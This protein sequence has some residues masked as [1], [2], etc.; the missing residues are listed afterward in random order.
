[1][2][3]DE[4]GLWEYLH[5]PSGI[6]FVLIIPDGPFLIGSSDDQCGEAS[7][8]LR[9]K[10]TSADPQV[11]AQRT[12]CETPR[13]TVELSPFLIAK[14][15]VTQAQ[16]EKVMPTNL[17]HFRGADLPVENVSWVESVE[18]CKK[19]KFSLTTEAQW[20]YACRGHTSTPF[21]FGNF[22][23]SSQVN[24]DGRYPYR[25]GQ[26]SGYQKATRPSSSGEVNSFGLRNMHG[27][28]AEWC[29]DDFDESF[30]SQALASGRDPI[31]TGRGFKKV[32]RGGS[33]ND[34]ASE[35][36][37][38]SRNWGGSQDRYPTVGFR[39]ALTLDGGLVEQ[40]TKASFA[41]A[42]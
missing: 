10:T 6:R 11:I 24:F 33:W 19:N 27:N 37:S 7:T 14:E 40:H 42:R 22:I 8:D 29:L 25:S 39:P 21:S 26:P 12:R 18:F 28:V 16:W 2:G 17:S 4:N 31:S 13:H 20:E 38:A 5:I 23:T 3:P 9:A 34:P 30:Y 35:C 36:R 41:S 32:I 1:M 15:E